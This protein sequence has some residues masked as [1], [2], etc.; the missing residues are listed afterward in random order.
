MSLANPSPSPPASAT[1]PLR[2]LLRA[3]GLRTLLA[4]QSQRLLFCAI[5]CYHRPVGSVPQPHDAR[6]GVLAFTGGP[7]A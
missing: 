7:S 4:V 2:H 1:P 6:A 3:V 5:G